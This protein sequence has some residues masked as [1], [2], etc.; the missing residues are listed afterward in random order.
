[1]KPNSARLV[2]ERL[3][4]FVTVFFLPIFFTYTG[5]RT[6]V[7]TL[8]GTLWL[9][10]GLVLAAAVIGKFGPLHPGGSRQRRLTARIRRHRCHDEHQRADGTDRD[11]HGLRNH[12]G[13]HHIHDHA[14][15]PPPH[16]L[17]WTR[18]LFP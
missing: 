18:T 7:G 10:C 2:Q 6:D 3:R 12:G 5:L 16:P 17:H 8:S 9:M 1:M 13:L 14:V 4:D 15:A 11:Q